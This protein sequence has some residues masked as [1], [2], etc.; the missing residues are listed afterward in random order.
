MRRILDLASY[1]P[2]VSKMSQALVGSRLQHSQLLVTV[3]NK[4]P[5][6]QEMLERTNC[7]IFGYDFSVDEFGPQ[8]KPEFKARTHFLRAAISSST[9]PS[10][11]PPSYTIQDLMQMNGHDYMYASLPRLSL[12]CPLASSPLLPLQSNLLT[13][14]SYSD[15]L[16]ID[17]EYA[18]F[19]ALSSLN[20]HTQDAG[21]EMPMGQ[22]LIELHL[23]QKQGITYPIFL[24]WWESM[25]YRGL[26][27]AWTEPNLLAVTVKL[28][29]GNPRLA[30]VCC[31]PALSPLPH[32]EKCTMQY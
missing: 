32:N 2:L 14:S 25:E 29:D 27:P 3:I 30:E 9:N 1:T 4:K 31:C 16:K 10:S 21:L 28:E 18:E 23:F 12:P 15:I 6:E 11:T 5:T 8:I 22:M 19:N 17:I 13:S 26:R 24:D 20:S 7:E